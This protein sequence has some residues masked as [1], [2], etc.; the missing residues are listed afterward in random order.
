[1]SDPNFRPNRFS[2]DQIRAKI[3]SALP[4]SEVLIQNL[5]GDGYHFDLIVIWNGFDGLSRVKQHQKILHIFTD[6]FAS[7]ALH[8]VTIKTFTK[9]AWEQAQIS[10]NQKVG[11]Q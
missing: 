7:N 4:D 11:I 8:A 1:M 10:Q 3:S 5:N 9:G 2:E 6:D